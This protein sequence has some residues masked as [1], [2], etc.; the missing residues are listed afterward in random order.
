MSSMV[1]KEGVVPEKKTYVYFENLD[2]V[3]AIAAWLVVISHIELHKIAIGLQ[4]IEWVH[5]RLVG[6]VGVTIF[7]ALSGFLITYLLLAE[8]E[9]FKKINFKDFYI[10][11]ILR[12]WPLYFLVVIVGFFIYPAQGSTNALLLCVFF[13]PNLAFSL[14]MLPSIF[15]PIWSIG[16]E[17][18]FYIFHP[19]VFRIKKT[20]NILYSLIGILF[21]L[22]AIIAVIRI[23]QDHSVFLRE[24]S[25]FF[26]FAR[27]TN[28]ILGAIVAVLYYNTKHSLFKF[29]FQN[30]FNLIFNKY[31][32]MCLF[33]AFIVLVLLFIKR[34]IPGGDLLMA[35]LASLLIVNLCETKS[36]IF[37]LNNS[38]LKYCGKI[39]YGIYLMHKFPLFLMLYIVSTYLSGT[40][41]LLQNLIIYI[42]TPLL[43][44]GLA[45]ISYYGYERFFLRLKSRFQKVRQSKAA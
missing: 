10:R 40:S 12:I 2:G 44:I 37:V 39:S 36:S 11:R 22:I 14:A 7:F 38:I 25:E 23:F 18:Q 45:S 24:L 41:V 6:Y 21:G 27:F 31:V 16:T 29:K 3:R 13:M 33:G 17:E 4:P 9:N 35:L 15:D 20:Q 5:S 43:V 32:Q 28:M 19:H 1:D 8:K 42:A 26:Y 30:L 34:E